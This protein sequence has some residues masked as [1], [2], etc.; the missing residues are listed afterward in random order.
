MKILKQKKQKREKKTRR[1]LLSYPIFLKNYRSNQKQF[2]HFQLY[3]NIF[4][5][6]NKKFNVFEFNKFETILHPSKYKI[7]SFNKKIATSKLFL[8]SN[9]LF[10]NFRLNFFLIKNFNRLIL[11]QNIYNNENNSYLFGR[12]L[13][14]TKTYTRILLSVFGVLFIIRTRNL[15][16]IIDKLM[17]NKFVLFHFKRKK[18]QKHS[19]KIHINKYFKLERGRKKLKKYIL[20]KLGFTLISLEQNLAVFS[21]IHYLKLM[22]KNNKKI[23]IKIFKNKKILK[24]L[25]KNS[26]Y[27]QKR[28]KKIV[29]LK[30]KNKSKKKKK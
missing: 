24:F 14:Q 13:K 30:K 3:E 20:K 7:A 1:I 11:N 26:L 9:R 12:I 16:Q 18:K 23:R 27:L 8:R 10:L 17:R 28:K 4:L 2:K 15:H 21:R 22:R 19:K 6:R 29:I 25:L 5:F